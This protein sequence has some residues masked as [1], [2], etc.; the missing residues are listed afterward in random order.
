MQFGMTM[1][2]A[3]LSAKE[4]ILASASPR[5]ARILTEMGL[6]FR[7]FPADVPEIP[8]DGSY[9]PDVPLL[10]AMNKADNVAARNPGYFVLG[11]DTVVELGGRTLGKPADPAA[12][13]TMLLAMSGREH[14]V[15][16]GICLTTAD[17]KTRSVFTETSSVLFKPFDRAQV[18]AY[19]TL[20]DPLDKA[21]AYGIQEHGEMLVAEVKGSLS[22]IIG[23][24][25]EKLSQALYSCCG[26]LMMN[27]APS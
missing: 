16:T 9:P 27:L 8:I 6:S 20:V 24:P 25:Q 17:R 14:K 23:L 2:S 1:T 18:K 11:A 19:L 12:A 22:N 26:R 21:G 5:R 4:I 3:T 15:I 10:N 13:E 7:V